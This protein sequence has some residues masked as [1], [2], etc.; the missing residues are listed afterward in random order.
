MT[1]FLNWFGEPPHPTDEFIHW[2]TNDPK[3]AAKKY[4]ERWDT[5]SKKLSKED[6]EWL[7]ERGYYK[8]EMDNAEKEADADL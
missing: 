7:V 1:R 4:R 8:S 3:T 2:S 6:M 5:I